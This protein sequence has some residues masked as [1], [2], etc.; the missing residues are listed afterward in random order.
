MPGAGT[1]IRV[2]DCSRNAAGSLATMVL[3]DFGADVIRVI[4]PAGDA[5]A[6]TP[7]YLLLQRGKQS[8]TLDLHSPAG[9][10]ELHRLVPGV[11]VVVE[12]AGPSGARRTRRS[13][14]TSS[15]ASIP[16][17]S[18]ARSRGSAAG[19]RSPTHPPRTRS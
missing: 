12:D 7:A 15:R 14:T 6:E 8:I 3:A 16:R 4:P 13:A 11:D 1:G 18:C 10:A 19:G 17:S 2:L 5:M 9:R